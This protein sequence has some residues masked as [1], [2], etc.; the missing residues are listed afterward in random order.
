MRIL[1]ALQGNYGKR[2]VKTIQRY[3]PAGWTLQVCTFADT[4][5]VVDDDSLTDLLPE[6]LPE[7]DL[8]LS[9]A[10][11]PGIGELIPDMVK[12]SDGKAVLA[13]VANRA[14]L[15]PGLA[16]QIK[17]KLA[18]MRVTM[19]TPVP[20][21]MLTG[22]ESDDPLIKE[23]ARYFGR[24]RVKV[25]E[26]QGKI[27][28]VTVLRDAPCGNTRFV[29]QKLVDC[30]IKDAYLE[31][32]LLHHAYVCFATMAMDREFGD[33]LMHRSGLA[34]KNAVA[35]AVKELLKNESEEHIN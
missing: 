35:E 22:N 2:I 5:P 28:K 25:D 3:M 31:A 27:V 16:N 1:T 14:W 30:G 11:D 34:T 23:F 9:L 4:L 17:R 32:G 13:P 21:C 6:Q 10:E 8:L 29:A 19:V 20:F 12:L 18:K 15:P 33:T 26:E 7:T 24:P